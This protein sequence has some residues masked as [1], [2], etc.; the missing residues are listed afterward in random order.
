[1]DLEELVEIQNGWQSRTLDKVICAVKSS[2]SNSSN[3]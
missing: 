2:I 3:N 1:M